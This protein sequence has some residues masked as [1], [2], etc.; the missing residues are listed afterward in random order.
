[1]NWLCDMFEMPQKYLQ[2]DIIDANAHS[3]SDET[4]SALANT[5]K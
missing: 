1:M 4:K 3:Q 2:K 5:K